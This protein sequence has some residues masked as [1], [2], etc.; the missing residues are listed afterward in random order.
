MQ[1]FVRSWIVQ[2][3]TTVDQEGRDREKRG[4]NERGRRSKA[5]RGGGGVL[6]LGT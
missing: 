1:R 2:V 3:V 4:K 6:G 5:K